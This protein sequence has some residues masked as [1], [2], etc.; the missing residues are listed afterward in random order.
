METF[1]TNTNI[2]T[3]VF[4]DNDNESGYFYDISC[5]I[6]LR[7]N[8][9]IVVE[10]IGT[11]KTSRRQ[12]KIMVQPFLLNKF[13]LVYLYEKYLILISRS[14]RNMRLSG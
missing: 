9:K 3:K 1:L 5:I 2:K 4:W 12:N 7:Q 6:I 11:P 14:D 10:A 13:E 8:F